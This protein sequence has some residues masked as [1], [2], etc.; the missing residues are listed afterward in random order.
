MTSRHQR[1]SPLSSQRWAL[2]LQTLSAQYLWR[3]VACCDES[4]FASRFSSCNVFVR[5]DSFH[6][7]ICIASHPALAHILSV[8]YVSIH[9]ATP[10]IVAHSTSSLGTLADRGRSVGLKCLYLPLVVIVPKQY[11]YLFIAWIILELRNKAY[12]VLMYSK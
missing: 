2:Y 3:S 11:L 1:A 5:I 10:V 8:T 4:S 12:Y 9:C 6:T 7:R